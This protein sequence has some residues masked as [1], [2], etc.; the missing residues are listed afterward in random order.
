M[1]Y[2]EPAYMPY[3]WTFEE[4]KYQDR[5]AELLR[6]DANGGLR[7]RFYRLEEARLC[8]WI[9]TINCIG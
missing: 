8:S 7:L 6:F 1:K 3:V 4:R 2:V 9:R 5:V